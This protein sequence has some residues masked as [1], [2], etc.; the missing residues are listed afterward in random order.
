[1]QFL[2]YLRAF[3]DD[4]EVYVYKQLYKRQHIDLMS[5]DESQTQ[6][7]EEVLKFWGADHKDEW[8][9]ER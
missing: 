7:W 5:R 1:M 4:T 8:R 2:D 9:E 3:I 6:C